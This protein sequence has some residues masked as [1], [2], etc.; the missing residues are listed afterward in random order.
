MEAI[1][2]ALGLGLYLPSG[3]SPF[4]FWFYPRAEAYRLVDNKHQ[5]IALELGLT[6]EFRKEPYNVLGKKGERYLLKPCYMAGLTVRAKEGNVGVS[7][8]VRFVDELPAPY[9][10]IGVK[11]FGEKHTYQRPK[12][13]RPLKPLW[14]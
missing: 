12:S 1:L 6:G 9:F 13:D 14:P 11:L 5:V 3:D 10:G 8:G 4:P 7:A 2:L